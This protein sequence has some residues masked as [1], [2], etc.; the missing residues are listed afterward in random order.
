MRNSKRSLCLSWFV[1]LTVGCGSS[2]TNTPAATP[3]TE[4][5][6]GS[7]TAAPTLQGTTTQVATTVATEVQTAVAG[8]QTPTVPTVPEVPAVPAT[9]TVATPTVATPTV[10]TPTVPTP[11]TVATPTPPAVPAAATGPQLVARGL[12]SFERVC[13]TCHEAGE[14]DGPAPNKNWAEARMRTTIRQGSGR[15][16]AIPATRLSDAD[17]DA[18]IAYLRTTHTVR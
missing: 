13:R 9:P 4:M 18:V 5:S 15:M 8:T 2:A 10:A 11:P 16:R 7:T 6:S 3:T 17:L 14:S 1:V 12:R